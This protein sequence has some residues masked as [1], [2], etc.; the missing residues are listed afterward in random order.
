MMKVVPCKILA[1]YGA[2]AYQVNLF[3]YMGLSTTLN[4]VELVDYKGPIPTSILVRDVD[5]QD[6]V[7]TLLK[8]STDKIQVEKILSSKL[9]N[10]TRKKTYMKHLMKLVGKPNSEVT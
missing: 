7:A 2:N 6:L 3:S 5:F 10:V 4:I 8:P 9:E 1:K